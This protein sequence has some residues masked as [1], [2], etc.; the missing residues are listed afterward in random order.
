MYIDKANKQLIID[1]PVHKSTTK[2]TTKAGKEKLNIK[3]IAHI[4]N[5][6]LIYLLEKFK[7]FDASSE[8]DAEY[9]DAMLSDPKNNE[10]KYYLSFYDNPGNEYIEM[11][12]T[13][14][15]YDDA[16]A[17]VTIKKQV[18]SN[19][20]FFTVSKKVFKN[21]SDD[22]NSVSGLRFILYLDSD[23]YYFKNSII[24]IELV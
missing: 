22:D 8:T 18:K 10:N 12:I 6:L 14:E 3:Y 23:N 7:S 19:S 9:I 16:I 21:L 13:K 17:S 5:I 11:N 20:Y 1:T 2:T 4:P 15:K 24:H